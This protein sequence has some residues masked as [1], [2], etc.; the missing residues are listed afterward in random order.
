MICFNGL[1]KPLTRATILGIVLLAIT[2]LSAAAQTNGKTQAEAQ[3][4]VEMAAQKIKD[5][6]EQGTPLTHTT[7]TDVTGNTSV[8]ATL[9][10][11]SV[12]RT[13][14]GKEIANHYAVISLTISNQSSD[15][16]FIVHS[17]FIDYSQWL[18]GGASPFSEPNGLCSQEQK[19]ASSSALS[20]KSKN[21][22]SS[23][24][25]GPSV[26]ASGS[27]SSQPPTGQD[28]NVRSC[29][30]NP[31]KT[32]QQQTSPNQLASVESRIVREEL[33]VK[34]PWTTRNWV[35]RA[36]QAA[37]SIATGFTF[38]ASSQSWIQGIGAFNGSVIPAYQNLF[39]DPT[40]NQMN[41]ISN[42]G[43]Q[44]NKAIAKQSSD[45]VV[46]FFP[47][48]RFLTPDLQ[49]LYLSSPAA[50]FSPVEALI[51]PKT[52]DK[53]S[54]YVVQIFGG[55][56]KWNALS[57]N[58]LKF[59]PQLGTGACEDSQNDPPPLDASNLGTNG[60]PEY[61][62]KLACLTAAA[63]NRLS[64]NTIRVIVGGTMT[65]DVD[66]V[67]SQIT[68]VDIDTPAAGVENMW[69][70]GS[71]SGTIHGSFLS[72][73]TPTLVSPPS[74]ATIKGVADGSTDTQLHFTL[75]LASDLPAGTSKLTFQVTK[76]G[77]KGSTIKSSTYDYPVQPPA[78]GE[79]LPAG[80]DEKGAAKTPATPAAVEKTPHNE[81]KCS[82]Y[83]GDPV[84]ACGP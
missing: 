26:D 49:S 47:L 37:G 63:V 9:I 3:K 41:Q 79:A 71:L 20:K 48:D 33:L 67:P 61:S 62:L 50:F 43:F 73:A 1:P 76:P 74:G 10:P 46:A 14:F 59:L 75:S 64:L 25:P 39:P 55:T 8:E 68:S 36:M 66:S 82:E 11:A 81:E 2:V 19:T 16:A 5:A 80:T 58:M 83:E 15:Y 60:N 56:E 72:G 51:D 31:L 7:S 32:Y 6:A 34:Q 30:G 24:K 78:A 35:L 57:N 40:V 17:V 77:T 13:V 69:K 21:V 65:V 12:A 18:L 42:V 84:V 38:A 23:Q 28:A 54:P 44:V 27:D 70:K 45:I 22:N 53:V 4:R 29:P 52:R